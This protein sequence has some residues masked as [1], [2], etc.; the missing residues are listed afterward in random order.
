M[1]P[2]RLIR[3]PSYQGPCI[4]AWSGRAAQNAA[5]PSMDEEA[6]FYDDDDDLP[7]TADAD[8]REVAKT[9]EELHTQTGG[10]LVGAAVAGSAA[11]TLATA[12]CALPLWAGAAAL[13]TIAGTAAVSAHHAAETIDETAK[14]MTADK[15]RLTLF[16]QLNRMERLQRT[17]RHGT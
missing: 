3:N 14:S 9:A 1:P 6:S 15:A 11:L 12:G 10:L 13:S 7:E 2:S 16:R 8:Q 5:L 4:K 17:P